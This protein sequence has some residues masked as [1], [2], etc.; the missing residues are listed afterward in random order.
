MSVCI[1]RI[2]ACSAYSISEW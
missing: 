2:L 1:D